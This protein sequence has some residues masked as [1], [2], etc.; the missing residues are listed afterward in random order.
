[1]LLEENH[2]LRR[3]TLELVQENLLAVEISFLVS[4]LARVNN[5]L[6][7]LLAAAVEGY[8]EQ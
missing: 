4:D 7:M 2:L 5:T 6:D 1:M 3:I 8:L